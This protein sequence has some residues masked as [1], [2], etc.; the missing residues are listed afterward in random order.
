MAALSL[1]RP[2]IQDVRRHGGVGGM[3]SDFGA[4]K[5]KWRM[6]FP[7]FMLCLFGVMLFNGIHWNIEAKIIPMIVGAGAMLFVSISLLNE[8]FAK[9]GFAGVAE[10]GAEAKAMAEKQA[11]GAGKHDKIHMDIASHIEHLP[12]RI[13]L[14]RGAIFFGWLI[15]FLCS[16][17]VIGLIPTVPL[18]VAA[19]MRLEGRERWSLVI[20]YMIG[21]TVF[22]YFLFDQLLAIPWPPT[23]LGDYFPA[24]KAIPSV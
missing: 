10:V 12:A 1:L 22:I 13:K 4:P 24:L 2:F 5:L 8:V 14:T 19:Y 20:P 15:A 6:V 7:F 16:M 21:M 11:A 9:P 23:Y 3:L 18:F 17:A